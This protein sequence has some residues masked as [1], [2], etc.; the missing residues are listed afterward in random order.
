MKTLHLLR[1]AKSSW[2]R[3]ELDD[4]ER[5]LSKRGRAAASAVAKAMARTGIAPDIVLCSTA[6]RARETL[7]PIAQ[8]LKP[9]KVVFEPGIYDVAGRK[10]WKYVLALPEGADTVLL[11][12]HNPGLHAFAL[13][14]ADAD[15]LGRLP[16]P[17]GKFPTGALVT[18][19][20]EGRWRDLRPRT[21]YLVS[22]V[23]PK[24]LD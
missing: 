17:E 14:L 24:E 2:K 13:S 9:P 21:A 7:T 23:Q 10:L 18:F 5:P 6:V 15:S 4:H 19:S 12:G 16:S 22:F 20:F 11:I 1:H 3:G 8:R